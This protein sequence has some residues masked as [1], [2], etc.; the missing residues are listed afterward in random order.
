MAEEKEKRLVAIEEKKLQSEQDKIMLANELKLKIETMKIQS[1]EKIETA[2]LVSA[3]RITMAEL[4]L[5]EQ[6]LLLKAKALEA[7]PNT[8]QQEDAHAL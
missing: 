5:K 1:E 3:E 4:K 6:E 8:T 7:K 2:K